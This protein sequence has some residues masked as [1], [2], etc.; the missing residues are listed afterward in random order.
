MT[1]SVGFRK[2]SRWPAAWSASA[3]IAAHC[4]EPELVPAKMKNAPA[5]PAGHGGGGARSGRAPALD[6]RRA[7]GR[8]RAGGARPDHAFGPGE[9]VAVWAPNLPE[10]VILEYAAAGRAGAGH[11][12][13]GLPAVRAG[14]RAEQSARPASSWSRSTAARWRF[15]R[16]SGRTCPR[17]GRWSSSP[18]GGFLAAAPD[19]AVTARRAARRRRAD[20][21]HLRHHRFPQGRR[22]ASPRADQQHPLLRRADRP[23]GRRGAGEPDAAVPHGRLRHGRTGSCAAPGRARPGAGLA[24]WP[25]RRAARGRAGRGLRQHRADHDDCPARH[26]VLE[27]RD[28]GVRVAS[29]RR[30]VPR[31]SAGWRAIGV[32]FSSVSGATEC[33]PLLTWSARCLGEDRAE[34]WARRC[35]RPRSRCRP[36]HRRAG[37]DRAAGQV[38]PRVLVMRGYHDAPEATAAAIDAEGWY[39][40]GDLA[41]IDGRGYLRIEGRLKDMIIRGGENIYPREIEDALFAHPGVAEAMVSASGRDLG[42]GDRRI[43]PPGP[44]QPA[45]ARRNCGR[46]AGSS[47]PR[48]RRLC[49]GCSWTPPTTASGKIQK[50]KLRESLPARSR[51]PLAS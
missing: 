3:V 37:A 34:G 5:P 13:P 9:R 16:R 20:P 21:V 24:T 35:R 2:P 15:R 10:W 50:Y 38:R 39:H 47:W 18:L 8:G 51:R 29:W 19:Q 23:A 4:G 17:C 44:G 30:E 46:T 49:T 32:R 22:A 14:L 42:R 33:S 6:L 11:R 7:P 48:S 27:R 26:P 43:R 31:W 41:S 1:Y 25:W 45:P 12:Q 28:V 40:T 36:G